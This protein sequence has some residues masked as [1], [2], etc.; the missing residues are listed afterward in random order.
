MTGRSRIILLAQDGDDVIT[1]D[2]PDLRILAETADVHVE[3]L[4]V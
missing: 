3:L 2:A 1:S 4:Q